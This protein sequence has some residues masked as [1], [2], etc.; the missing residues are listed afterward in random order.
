M[1]LEFNV[2]A[3]VANAVSAHLPR[4]TGQDRLRAP[5]GHTPESFRAGETIYKDGDTADFV[6]EVVFGVVRITT[7]ACNGHRTVHAFHAA[8]DVFGIERRS[9]R[10]SCAEAVSEAQVLRCS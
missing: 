6:Y 5:A 7:I 8:G 3:R 9:T 1:L 10:P 2:D 4:F